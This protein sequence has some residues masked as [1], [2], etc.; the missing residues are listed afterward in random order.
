MRALDAWR[1]ASTDEAAPSIEWRGDGGRF[2]D[3]VDGFELRVRVEPDEWDDGADWI[4]T[5]TDEWAPGAILT[6]DERRYRENA[7]EGG[8]WRSRWTR[9]DYRATR[10]RLYFVPCYSADERRADYCARGMARHV[11]DCRARA[12]VERDY[13]ALLDYAP[14]SVV[15]VEAWREGVRLGTASMGGVDG[16]DGYREECARELADEALDDARAT[17]ARLATT[18]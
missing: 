5:L 12:D 13:R 15:T 7:A 6:D 8:A 2:V 14:P 10:H 17:L 4:G 9:E 11:A 18:A 3:P 16:G 1:A